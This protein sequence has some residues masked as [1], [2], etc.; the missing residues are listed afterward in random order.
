MMNVRIMKKRLNGMI[1]IPVQ[2]SVESN[3][4]LKLNNN[5][6]EETA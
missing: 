6:V 2:S 4:E 5:S 3:A 1:S